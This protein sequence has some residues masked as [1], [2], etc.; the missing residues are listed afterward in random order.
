MEMGT[1]TPTEAAL[2]GLHVLVVDDEPSV[3]RLLTRVL[4]QA[5]ARVGTASSAGEALR[6][7]VRTA[8]DLLL[9]D[10]RMPGEDG[11]H[12]IEQVRALPPERGGQTPAVAFTGFADADDHA[13]SLAAGFDAHLMKPLEPQR[14]V[15]LL[16]S[17]AGPAA[18][19]W[20]VTG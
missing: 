8:P 16:A 14:L 7:L 19:E 11:Y 17:L 12:L 4:E 6:T 2:D 18:D 20:R 3:L 10:I 13:F 1:P 15:A 5:G 9:T